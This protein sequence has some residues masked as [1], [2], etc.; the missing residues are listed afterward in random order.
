LIQNKFQFVEISNKPISE[1]KIK[2][3]NPF[4]ENYEGKIKE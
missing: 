2:E 1:E 4:F 3:N